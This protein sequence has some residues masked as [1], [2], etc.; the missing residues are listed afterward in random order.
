MDIYSFIKSKDVAA[1]CREIGKTWNTFE[2][3]VIIGRKSREWMNTKKHAAWR[4]LIENYPD[5][6]VPWD[7]RE[8][9]FESIHKELEKRIAYEERV[10]ARFKTPESGAVYYYTVFRDDDEWLVLAEA[11][12]QN[13]GSG[14]PTYEK[15]LES[16]KNSLSEQAEMDKFY[17]K[18]VIKDDKDDNTHIDV[19]F[20]CDGN[21]AAWR[22]WLSRKSH[23]KLFPDI[24][25]DDT[26]DWLTSRRGPP[27]VEIPIPFKRG[28]ILTLG[29]DDPLVFDS[30]EIS[31]SERL[32]EEIDTHGIFNYSTDI[33][34]YR[35][36]GYGCIYGTYI[37]ADESYEYYR[38]K[39]E[40]K[41]RI[42]HYLSL[43]FKDEIGI[44][45]LLNMQCRI[46][47]EYLLESSF[48][49]NSYGCYISE[50]HL[51]ENRLTEEEKEHIEQN[52]GV[53]PWVSKKLSVH[54]VEFLMK[55]TGD[56]KDEVQN[57]LGF[58]S[59]GFIALCEKI[60]RDENRYSRTNDSRF[61]ADRRAM[62][63][64]VLESYGKTEDR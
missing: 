54:Q 28:D 63:R 26:N 34:L 6:P 12:R 55:E 32:A 7:S 49:L 47:M 52:G 30:P 36:N 21:L 14:F 13:Y 17:I 1:H 27:Y 58:N 16:A 29:S 24:D 18:K 39:L 10:L 48:N 64:L 40:G 45:A 44:V 11:V 41:N 20:D 51:A 33:R 8:T 19:G 35:V 5:M 50:E 4:E 9:R 2:M 61:N 57:E 15:A 38:G 43:Y 42:L 46:M 22:F 31:D 60:V 53:M 37:A 59:K 23:A 3:A 56:T 25:F 62:A